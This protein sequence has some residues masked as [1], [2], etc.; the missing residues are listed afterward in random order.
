M[1]LHQQNLNG[2]L[3]VYAGFNYCVI[4]LCDIAHEKVI[5]SKQYELFRIKYMINEASLYE[6]R[7][8]VGVSSWRN[9]KPSSLKTD[10]TLAFVTTNLHLQRLKV[11][12]GTNEQGY[13]V[14]TFGAPSAHSMKYSKGGLRRLLGNLREAYFTQSGGDNRA[15]RAKNKRIELE[16]LKHAFK[17]ICKNFKSA[18]A[19]N[20][21]EEVI[22]LSTKLHEKV[23]DLLKYYEMTFI[24]DSLVSLSTS[25][26][27]PSTASTSREEYGEKYTY[28][29][30][31]DFQPESEDADD[32]ECQVLRN[33]IESSVAQILKMI[34]ELNKESPLILNDLAKKSWRTIGEKTLDS[35]VDDVYYFVDALI[36]KLNLGMI[37]VLLQ[38]ESRHAQTMQDLRQRRD[39]CLSQ[40]VTALICG[41]EAKIYTSLFDASFM[42]QLC[43]I[44]VL[45][46]FECLLSTYGDEMGMLEDMSIAIRDLSCVKFKFACSDNETIPYVTGTRANIHVTILLETEYFCYLP[47]ELQEGKL[48]QVSPV[49]FTQGINEHAT[50][51]E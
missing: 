51:A 33:S 34:N 26:P 22:E 30:L 36:K 37:F 44:G 10:K 15:N 31:N 8:D 48:I 41:F 11:I 32:P 43:E 16:L 29:G 42:K 17:D 13:D 9:F 21:L 12:D 45:A 35:V 19:N 25:R 38:E 24:I 28:K 3:S 23:N 49:I 14:V 7:Q 39:I 46:E 1:P 18:L 27:I 6:E 5:I 4:L 50:L 20:N 47:K 2:I 40:A